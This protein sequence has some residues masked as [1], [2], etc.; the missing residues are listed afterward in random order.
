MLKNHSEGDAMTAI[1]RFHI[2][3]TTAN[4][5]N[6]QSILLIWLNSFIS[7]FLTKHKIIKQRWTYTHNH[8]QHSLIP[9][10]MI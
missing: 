1:N 5:D 2:Y 10:Y 8:K 4:A 6:F 3:L 9:L 7:S